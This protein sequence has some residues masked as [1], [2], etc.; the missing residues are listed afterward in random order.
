MD[1]L[2]ISMDTEK[3]KIRRNL[4]NYDD[5]I[6]IRGCD[7]SKSDDDI[8]NEVRD[9]Y[10]S[11]YNENR[12]CPK[13]YARVGN[14]ASH[15][16]CLNHIIQKDLENTIILEDDSFIDEDYT[17]PDYSSFPKDGM[18]MLSGRI[19]PTTWTGQR[20]WHRSGKPQQI[21]KTFEE[22]IN[23]VH[24]DKYRFT[25]SNAYFV[26]NATVASKAVEKIK[27]EKKYRH[28]DILFSKLH[29][30][31]YLYY[32]AP[33]IHDDTGS[34]SQIIK[35]NIGKIKN[36]QMIVGPAREHCFPENYID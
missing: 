26:P 15:L 1:K 27:G 34:N 29:L 25:Q 12:E 4:L 18:T 14:L 23:L 24:Y 16:K 20:E 33:Y 11:R 19:Q 22:G 28:T 2:L 9:K 6:W 32:P 5:F 13:F 21:I 7:G 3:G 30:W 8:V 10:F 36:Y 35:G 17:V 31:K